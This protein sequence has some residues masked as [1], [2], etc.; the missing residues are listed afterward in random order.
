MQGLD[1]P[2]RVSAK[3]MRW[4]SSSYVVGASA[5]STVSRQKSI[6]SAPVLVALHAKA[7]V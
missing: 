5:L 7:R 4:P 1:A 3:G 2:M 6:T